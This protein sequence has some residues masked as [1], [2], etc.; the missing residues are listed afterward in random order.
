VTSP[1]TPR[2]GLAC[3]AI[4][5]VLALAPRPAHAA[6]PDL[7]DAEVARRLAFIEDRLDRGTAAAERWWYGWYTGWTALAVGEAIVAVA[8]TNK[9]TRV[10]AAV[11]AFGSSLATLPFGLFPFPARYAFRRLGSLPEATP[12]ERRR[13]LGHAEELL[14]GAAKAETRG[15]WWVTHVLNAVGSVAIGG[16][17][18]AY[19]QTAPTVVISTLGGIGLGEAQIWTQPTAAIDDLRAYEVLSGGGS[20][21]AVKPAG[22]SW[23]LAPVGAGLGVLGR[24]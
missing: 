4:A 15:R 18:L 22:V 5:A 19:K 13:K 2:T 20:P 23:S 14:R 8:T 16:L 10:G 12:A 6:P 9:S 17:L 1:R 7:P 3:L 24:F 11:G 21:P